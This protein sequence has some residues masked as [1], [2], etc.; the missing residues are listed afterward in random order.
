MVFKS[1]KQ[2]NWNV[3][4]NDIWNILEFTTFSIILDKM[5]TV[6]RFFGF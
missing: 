6:S 1:Y 2:N 5:D 3:G 4:T